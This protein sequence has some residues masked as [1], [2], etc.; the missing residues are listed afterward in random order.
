MRMDL[1]KSRRGEWICRTNAQFIVRIRTVMK[2][3]DFNQGWWW[4]DRETLIRIVWALKTTTKKWLLAW[5]TAGCQRR[6]RSYLRWP[7]F[8]SCL[9]QCIIVTQ[10]VVVA[11]FDT[12]RE[13]E[14]Q[15]PLHCCAANDD[16]YFRVNAYSSLHGMRLGHLKSWIS[17]AITNA[18][19][20]RANE[21]KHP[22]VTTDLDNV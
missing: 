22:F 18:S 17:Q 19:N 5:H 16:D 2:K 10:I 20:P 3:G 15:M 6:R 13:R 12:K 8:Y 7:T 1:N 4:W 14:R 21:Q 11:I 9:Q